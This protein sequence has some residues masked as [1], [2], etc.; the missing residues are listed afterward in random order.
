MDVFDKM[1]K[2]AIRAARDEDL[3]DSVLEQIKYIY[4]NKTKFTDISL[5]DELVE[6]LED[7]EPFADVGC[8]NESYSTADVKRAVENILSR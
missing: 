3:P 7:Y 8:G 2:E 1:L 6:R 5:I 4:D